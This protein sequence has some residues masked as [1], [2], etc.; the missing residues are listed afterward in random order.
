[1]AEELLGSTQIAMLK[2]SLAMHSQSPRVQAHFQIAQ[3][4]ITHGD[5]KTA[6]FVTI[7]SKVACS[8]AELKR[9]IEKELANAGKTTKTA[10]ADDEEIYSFDHVYPG[11]E[12]NSIVAILYGELGSAEF[13]P[14]HEYLKSVA[15]KGVKYVSRHYVKVHI[16]FNS[17]ISENISSLWP[18]THNICLKD[19][20]NKKVRLSG[21]GV[22]LYLKSTEYKSQDDSAR[23]DDDVRDPK[24]HEVE[25]D[26]FDF[27]RLKWVLYWVLVTEISLFFLLCG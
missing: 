19:L 27:Q 18:N 15:P 2:V 4:V 10:D 3:E 25:L 11:S 13:Q 22:E 26:G 12:N 21:Y 17:S 7:G 5:C 6:T 16:K 14:F 8:L 20:P 9:G 24:D 1:M 23:V